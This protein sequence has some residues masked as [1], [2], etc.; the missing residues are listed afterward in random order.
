LEEL[1]QLRVRDVSPMSYVDNQGNLD[2]APSLSITE[3]EEDGLWLKNEPSQ[4]V[5]PIHPVAIELGREPING[6]PISSDF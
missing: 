3:D 6:I 5:V 1:G 4:R 2:S